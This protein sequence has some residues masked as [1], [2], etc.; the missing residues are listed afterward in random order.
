MNAI[1]NGNTWRVQALIQQGA[2]VNAVN[3]FGVSPLLAAAYAGHLPIVKTLLAAGANTHF[4]NNSGET[5][6]DLARSNHHS[7]IVRLLQ[8][9]MHANHIPVPSQAPPPASPSR[10]PNPPAAAKAPEPNP[11]YPFH[12][13]SMPESASHGNILVAAVAF[14]FLVGTIGLYARK[15][16]RQARAD[17]EEE[18]AVPGKP[19]AAPPRTAPP[20]PTIAAASATRAPAPAPASAAKETS[21]AASFAAPEPGKLLGGKYE[22]LRKIGAGGMGLVY[23]GLDRKLDRRVAVKKMREE[24]KLNLRERRR[25]LEEA[26]TSAKL[27]HPYIVDIYDVI[28]EGDDGEVYLVF[29]YV[30]GKTLEQH[31][32]KQG[33]LSAAEIKPLLREVTEA[34]SYAHQSRVIHRDLKPSNV[35]ATSQ[36]HAKVMDFG[37]ARQMKDTVSRVTRADSSGTMAYMAPEQELGRYDA[38]SDVFA[39]GATAYELLTGELPFPGPNFLVQKRESA[40]RPLK[41]AAPGTPR[42][43]AEAVERCI[44]ADPGAR[45][46][47]A[48]EFARAIA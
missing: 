4:M 15:Y 27:H 36:G 10:A 29:E 28:E 44:Q 17:R 38:R 37:I 7:D 43:M 41:E 11:A 8:S 19:R 5:A 47:T 3:A 46:Q 21:L 13:P 25:F 33:R 45:F 40:F 24:I 23:E 12:P 16:G 1:A 22:L 9:A 26:R 31:L 35:M 30:D 18:K 20:S 14:F 6:L 39:L 42:E 32:D 2:N 34:L 48:E